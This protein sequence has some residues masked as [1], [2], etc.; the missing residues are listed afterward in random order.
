M[1]G[2]NCTKINYKVNLNMKKLFLLLL[3]F[4]SL[5]V[6]AQAINAEK[7]LVKI[8]NGL[9]QGVTEQSGVRS[10]KGIPY[11]QPPV[12]N[13]R[14]KA[15]AEPLNWKGVKVTDHFGP[16]AMQRYMYADM[17][18]RST[19]NSE[20]C[21]YLNVWA[22]A[23]TAGEKLPVLVYFYGGG[24]TT[25]DGS[26]GRYD[27]ES[28][29]KSGVVT[30][31]LNYRLGV[32]GF[33]AHP[34]LTRESAQH[35]SGNYGLMDQ[36]AALLWVQKNI[37]A[38]GGDPSRVTIAGESAGAASVCAQM[39]TP[40]SKHLF[41]GAIG[42]SGSML[43]N[44]LPWTLA[45][46]ERNGIAFAGKTGKSSV[47]DL[48]KIP[49]DSLLKWSASS[50][51]PI[52]VDG[53]FFPESPQVIFA[54]GKQMDVPLLAGWNSAEVNYHSLLGKEVP[55]IA[56]YK[57]ALNKLYN[58]RAED[59]LRLYPAATDAD[60]EQV[61]T[62][63]ASDRFIAYGTW[64]FIDLHSKTDGKPVYRYLFTRKRPALIG[65]TGEQEKL[66]GAVHASEIDYAMG[67]L[68]YNKFYNWTPD[69]YKTS[70]T[71]QKYFVNFIK[72]GDP[73]GPGL[74]KW[75]GL[76]SSIPKVMIIDADSHSVPEKNLKRYVLL[77]TFF[78][79]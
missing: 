36:H 47:A 29:A 69:D 55:T 50:H 59:V 64:K 78:N 63:L 17:V 43:G 31:T 22:P 35:S 54:T 3:I 58:D 57:N 45:D 62:D 9:L 65:A 48:R 49:A 19:S 77:D 76:Q 75:Y 12:G 53:Y 30:V 66:F 37:E 42:E 60:V 26:E 18:F 61:A 14:W 13:L 7:P 1:F 20:D 33:L 70:E 44:L 25:G 52:V 2:N 16:R 41:I 74:S 21:L 79:K 4:K 38:F 28:M 67:N 5:T 68:A 40:L 8:S 39:A 71:M 72:T 46:G 24:F 6:D 51:F 23:K 73:N 15:P 27:G 32:F 56:N 34:E 11:A 10:F